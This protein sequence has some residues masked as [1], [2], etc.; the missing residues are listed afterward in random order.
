MVTSPLFADGPL[1]QRIGSAI[2]RLALLLATWLAF[3]LLAVDFC[4]SEVIA[5]QARMKMAQ[6]YSCFPTRALPEISV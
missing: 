3:F 2:Q 1:L 4:I 5:L 6:F